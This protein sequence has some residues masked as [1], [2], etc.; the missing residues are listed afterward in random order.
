MIILTLS[1]IVIVYLITICFLIYGFTKINTIDSIGLT[2][3][4]K[5]SIVIPFRDE[6]ENLPVLLESLSKLNYPMEYFEV[7]LVDDDSKEKPT[8]HRNT[9]TLLSN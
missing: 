2:P 7:I 6:A 8:A 9:P 4:I 3:K 5:F 1:T